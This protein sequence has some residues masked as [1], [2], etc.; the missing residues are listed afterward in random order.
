MN[1]TTISVLKDR[2]MRLKNYC[3]VPSLPGSVPKFISID[4]LG[5]T[6]LPIPKTGCTNWKRLIMKI[7]GD[8]KINAIRSAPDAAT[9]YGYLKQK[10]FKNRVERNENFFNTQPKFIIVREPFQRL[11]S[12]YEVRKQTLLELI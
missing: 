4:A 3:K 6:Y 10:R 12:A 8:D 1:W 11:V 9:E 5:L 2:A 7:E